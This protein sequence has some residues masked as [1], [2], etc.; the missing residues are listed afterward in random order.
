MTTLETR[1]FAEPIEFR[2]AENGT[3][4]VAA[5]VAIKYGVKSKIMRTFREVI[6]PGAA[7]QVLKERDVKALHEHDQHKILGRLSAG[8]LRIMNDQREMAFEIDI[9]DTSYGRDLAVSLERRDVT[10]AS[11][12]F[13]PLPSATKTTIDD[14]GMA[15]RT[16]GTFEVFDHISTTANPAYDAHTAELA[17]RSYAE[18][19]GLDLR[20]L[21]EASRKGEVPQLIEAHTGDEPTDDRSTDGRETTVVYRTGM[22][23]LY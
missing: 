9:P 2:S 8:T 13:R 1:H 4:L 7:D 18:D 19:E 14:D 11:F 10:G 22:S 5:G 20:S 21:I 17:M 6:Q 15:L 16:V 12:G 23:W 3:K